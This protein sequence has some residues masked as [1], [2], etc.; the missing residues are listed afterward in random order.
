V[1]GLIS[2]TSFVKLLPVIR[3]NKNILSLL[4]TCL[5]VE[6]KSYKGRKIVW[7]AEWF[8]FC[9]LGPVGNTS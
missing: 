7:I 5:S 8:Q 6:G 9:L 3:G 4:F 2:V 1:T